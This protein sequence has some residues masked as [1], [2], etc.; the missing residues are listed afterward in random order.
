MKKIV[1][2]LALGLAGCSTLA[3]LEGTTISPTQ[4]IV[5]A[6]SFDAAEATATNY[7]R[8]PTCP[9]A[10]LCKT[11]AGIN[12]IVLAIRSGRKARSDLEAYVN[13]NPGQPAPVTLYDA[14]TAAVS[15]LQSALAQ[16]NA[17]G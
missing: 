8:L 11:Q 14:L 12:A 5:A 7:L 10:K 3:T 1:L 17:Q 13:A 16:Y 2:L 9:A 6:N 4:V 15:T